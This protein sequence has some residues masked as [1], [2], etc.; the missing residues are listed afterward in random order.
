M[1]K[2]R[3]NNI[4][5][6]ILLPPEE[7]VCQVCATKHKPEEPHNAKSLY[8]QIVFFEK[9]QRYPTWSD[10][11]SHCDEETKKAWEKELRRRNVWE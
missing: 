4:G 11:L 3:L 5:Q 7:D 10:A 1:I 2:A 6:L 8:Y 9:N